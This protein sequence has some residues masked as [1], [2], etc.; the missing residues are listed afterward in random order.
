VNRA[1]SKTR[2]LALGYDI[3]R[4]KRTMPTAERKAHCVGGARLLDETKGDRGHDDLAAAVSDCLCTAGTPLFTQFGGSMERRNF[5]KA[6]GAVGAGSAMGAGLPSR[7]LATTEGL[8]KMPEA[9]AEL[10]THTKRILRAC[11]LKAGETFILASSTSYDQDYVTAMLTAAGEMGAVGAHIAV[12]PKFNADGVAERNLHDFHWQTYAKA[13]LLVATNI[14]NTANNPGAVTAYGV[15]VAK[16]QYR[17]DME[18]LNRAGSTTRWLDLSYDIARQ[19]KYMPTAE[20]KARCVRGA[21]LIDENK[22]EIR[23]TKPDGT[24]LRMSTVGRPGHAQYGAADFPGK[25]DNFGYGCVAVGPQ[26]NSWEGTLVLAPGDIITNLFPKVLEEPIKLTFKGGYVTAFEG[27]RRARE[28]QALISSFNNKESFGGSHFGW[29][30]H[31]NTDLQTEEDVGHYH[32]NKMGV[33]LIALG[34]NFAHGLGG[35]EAGYSG[36]GNTTRVA[37]NHSH[38]SVHNADVYVAG[39]KVIEGGRVDTAAG[40]L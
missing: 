17:T 3:H 36:L 33:L 15:K 22:G 11:D 34:M 6:V 8:N 27:G 16:H 5:L 21:R 37:P 14:G 18:F 29:G 13:N 20:R 25:W 10:V 26:E 7:L 1:G 35:P 23:V 28:F 4:Q 39:R 31:E 19:K 30:I 12:F 9:G 2:G 38:F 24:D 32:H 40:G